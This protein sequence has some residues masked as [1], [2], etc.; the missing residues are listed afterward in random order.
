MKSTYIK[1]TVTSVVTAV[2]I[3]SILLMEAYPTWL[4]PIVAVE[5]ILIPAIYMIAQEF[6]TES[7]KEETEDLFKRYSGFKKGAKKI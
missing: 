2:A 1:A 6:I 7:V 3:A 5:V 4:R